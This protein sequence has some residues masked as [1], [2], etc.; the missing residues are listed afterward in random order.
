MLDSDWGYDNDYRAMNM[1]SGLWQWFQGYNND[2]RA[3]IMIA[4]LWQWFQ[5]YDN[6]CR[7]MTMIAGL[8]HNGG[9][10]RGSAERG[11]ET[12]NRHSACARE[13]SPDLTAWRG[14]VCT[15]SRKRGFS[16]AS[17]GKGQFHPPSIAFR[18][19]PPNPTRI[20]YATEGS[21]L[22][23]SIAFRHLPPNPARIGYATEGALQTPSTGLRHPSFN[24]CRI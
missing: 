15:G 12:K 23:P 2:C 7:A 8:W 10:K 4:G 21:L 16:A 6:D 1:V 3:M 14:Y 18:H 19:L 5:G 22:T 9:R 24:H 20:G 11:S 13:K 17:T